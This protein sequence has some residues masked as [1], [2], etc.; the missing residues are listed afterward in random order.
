MGNVL[1]I[2]DDPEI[3]DAIESAAMRMGHQVACSLTLADGLDKVGSESFDIVLL[4]VRLPDGDGLD[5]LPTIQKVTPRA[6]QLK[7]EP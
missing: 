2:D 5:A 6:M 4:D 7:Q 1:V 3:C